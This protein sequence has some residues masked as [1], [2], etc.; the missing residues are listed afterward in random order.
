[1]VS[2]IF[3]A[4]HDGDLICNRSLNALLSCKMIS[5]NYLITLVFLIERFVLFNVQCI[6]R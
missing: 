5:K 4:D 2:Y 6:G 1:M 3:T